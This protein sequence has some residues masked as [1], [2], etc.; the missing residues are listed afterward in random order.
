MFLAA[1][2]VKEDDA[3]ILEPL[4]KALLSELTIWLFS[5]FL[6]L[7]VISVTMKR[8]YLSN[9]R[10]IPASFSPSADSYSISNVEDFANIPPE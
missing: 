6:L 8:I 9:D 7:S 4:N 1:Y 2:E 3:P 10:R 5:T